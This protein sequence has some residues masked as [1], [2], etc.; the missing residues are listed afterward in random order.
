MECLKSLETC[1]CD[2]TF[3]FQI[4]ERVIAHQVSR[5]KGETE[6]TEYLVKWCGLPYSDCTWEEEHLIARRFQDKIDAY[7]ARRA[8]TK[9]PTRLATVRLYFLVFDPTNLLFKQVGR[10]TLRL[11][12]V[13]KRPKFEKI[14]LIPGYLQRKDD[15]EHE[16]RDYQL[17]GV[18]WMLHAWSKFVSFYNPKCL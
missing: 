3:L 2:K 17:E 9:I 14:Q 15:S 6:G 10:V 11:Q 18:N 16:L 1:R 13:K 5:E 12:A 7:H 4:V 8:N